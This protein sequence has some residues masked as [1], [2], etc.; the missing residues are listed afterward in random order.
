[1]F[2]R[3]AIA[4]FIIRIPDEPATHPPSRGISFLRSRADSRPQ[5]QFP[6]GRSAGSTVTPRPALRLVSGALGSLAERGKT[7]V[8]SDRAPSRRVA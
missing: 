4:L 3:F 1:M 6:F 5:G 7:L 2:F 8:I